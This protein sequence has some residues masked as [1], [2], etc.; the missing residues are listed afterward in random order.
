MTTVRPNGKK[1]PLTQPWRLA[2]LYRY[3]SV[4]AYLGAIV[5]ANWLVATYG[6]VPV[7]FGLAATAGTYA[8]GL[9]FVARDAV[10]DSAGRGW[11]VAALAG[12]ALLSWF[13][14]TP[15]LAVASAVAFGLSELADMAVYTPL[16]RRGYVRA[17]MA[18]NLVGTVVDTY[19][20]LWLAGFGVAAVVVSG[21]L[22]G[23]AYATLAVVL[24]VVAVRAVLRQRHRV[25][26]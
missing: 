19:L 11:A 6:F 18:S 15:Q 21:Q 14:S 13:L 24:V 8:A 5:L 17:A 3:F 25:V 1:T 22:V 9:A 16:R 4:L 23:K 7:G 10:Q 12:G 20:F 26:A 2:L